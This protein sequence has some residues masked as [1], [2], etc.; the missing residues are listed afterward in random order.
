MEGQ[1]VVM[2]VSRLR[3]HRELVRC[4]PILG[5]LGEGIAQNY[6]ACY[7]DVANADKKWVT[8]VPHS[9]KPSSCLGWCRVSLA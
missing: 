2:R 7:V 5:R 8:D 3:D 4:F 1:A 6:V 9:L